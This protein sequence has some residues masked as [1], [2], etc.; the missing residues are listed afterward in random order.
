MV[1]ALNHLV[2][3]L[4]Q[5]RKMEIYDKSTILK[6]ASSLAEF[7]GKESME[8][9]TRDLYFAFRKN[10]EMF[11]K[12]FSNI[13]GLSHRLFFGKSDQKEIMLALLEKYY[14]NE[15]FVKESF[16]KQMKSKKENLTIRFEL[17]V[18]DSRVDMLIP[19]KQ[20]YA[21]EIK[22]EYDTLERL[23][24][25]IDDYSKCFNYV[26]VVTYKG[27][28]DA[29][30]SHI[31]DNCGIMV[32]YKTA[33]FT[34]YNKAYSCEVTPEAILEVMWKSERKKAFGISDI[35]A[36]ASSYSNAEICSAFGTAISLRIEN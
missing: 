9:N 34:L 6:I 10:P 29:V 13:F 22:T 28:E 30:S 32:Y 14:R 5:F 15:Y 2:L 27:N 36:I 18:V 3:L 21:Y 7:Y 12:A 19:G 26:F 1:I 33:K 20:N 35:N 8:E 4:H 25:Q 16:S 11:E 17:P 31:P 23:S 24:K